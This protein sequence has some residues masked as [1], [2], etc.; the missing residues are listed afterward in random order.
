V[1]REGL[2][3]VAVGATA[4]VACCAAPI[5]GVLGLT[6]GVAAVGWLLGGV[7]VALAVLTVGLGVV[8]RR[9]RLPA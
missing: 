7:L 5:L 1:R 8:R 6:V 4:C 2:S 3:L 9:R